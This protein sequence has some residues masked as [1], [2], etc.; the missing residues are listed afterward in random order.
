MRRRRLDQSTFVKGF[1]GTLQQFPFRRP[2]LHPNATFCYAISMLYAFTLWQWSIYLIPIALHLQEVLQNQTRWFECWHLWYRS[3]WHA[4][5]S[6]L[7]HRSGS[8]WCPGHGSSVDTTAFLALWQQV[9]D[10]EGASKDTRDQTL[11]AMCLSIFCSQSLHH[12]SLR[13]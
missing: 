13:P 3:Y 2:F 4:N 11:E 6:P 7:S 9:V 10:A 1:L 8:L 12:R 5:H